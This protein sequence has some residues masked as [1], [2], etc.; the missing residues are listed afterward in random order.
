MTGR[1]DPVG[2]GAQPT[3]AS[4]A[5]FGA[6][7]R[8][9]FDGYLTQC[10]VCGAYSE[11]LG[12][13]V[14]EEHR[15]RAAE[16]RRQF[17]FDR[18]EPLVGGPVV[19]SGSEGVVERTR[20]G[21]Q[22]GT[23][24]HW[25]V[26]LVAI[27]WESWDEATA[28]AESHGY[29][30]RDIASRLGI[31]HQSARTQAEGHGARLRRP[32]EFMVDAA[33]AHYGEHGTLHN[34][35]GPL[36]KFIKKKRV[37][38]ARGV[39]R[40]ITA[41]LNEIDPEWMLTQRERAAQAAEQGQR[42]ENAQARAMRQRWFD[43]FAR[44][45]WSG[46]ADAI[47]WAAGNHG[48]WS[49]IAEALDSRSDA[50]RAASTWELGHDG[51]EGNPELMNRLEPLRRSCPRH[52]ASERGRVQCHVCLLWFQTLRR[53][54]GSHAMS[55]REYRDR[56]ALTTQTLD[57]EADAVVPAPIDWATQFGAAGLDDWEGALNW[58]IDTEVGWREV[59]RRIGVP[60]ERVRAEAGGRGLRIPSTGDIALSIARR[61]VADGG[62]LSDPPEEILAWLY[63]VRHREQ[64]GHPSRFPALLNHI[65]PH[66]RLT[67]AEFAVLTRE[68]FSRQVTRDTE[69]TWERAIESAGFANTA[70]LLAWARAFQATYSG[71]GYAIG[72]DETAVRHYLQEIDE[73]D[74]GIAADGPAANQYFTGGFRLARYHLDAHGNLQMPTGELRFWLMETHEGALDNPPWV[75][76][77]LDRMDPD[78]RGGL[79]MNHVD[80]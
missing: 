41:A 45:G 31:S 79:Q 74:D 36:D 22:R 28:W 35:T 60:F 73:V 69:A 63:R 75:A 37:E 72:L 43:G 49:D 34:A 30:W 39:A 5:I 80:G 32:A 55:A 51:I 10:H 70:A 48:N 58:A 64:H 16:Y 9:E 19:D 67:R 76:W 57:A 1:G 40:S 7:G 4:A 47:V 68:R 53:H 26:R 15:M 78:W 77:V 6:P 21:Q 11:T 46:W 71:I 3:A 50:A 33:R 62:T 25:N 42:F 66:W 12:E 54:L 8:W 52:L 20:S 38:R 24:R 59:A 14:G 61:H 65:D 29:G 23:K 2:A 13:H 17:G 27:G 18:F 56:F 44:N